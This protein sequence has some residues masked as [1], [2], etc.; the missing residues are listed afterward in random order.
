MPMLRRDAWSCAPDD[1]NSTFVIVPHSIR[2]RLLPQ[3]AGSERR[4]ITF[5][6][7]LMFLRDHRGAWVF[8]DTH[9]E[10]RRLP[11]PVDSPLVV[12]VTLLPYQPLG[13]FVRGPLIAQENHH[14]TPFEV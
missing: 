13:T 14:A 8:V 7:D 12:A 2:Y 6:R 3:N 4:L 5:T 10:I 9:S 1:P 11:T